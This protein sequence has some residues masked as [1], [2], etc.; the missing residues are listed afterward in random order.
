MLGLNMWLR[1]LFRQ[2]KQ[3]RSGNVAI[4]FGLTCI[5]LL[6]AIGVAV[7]YTRVTDIRAKLDGVAD[8]ATLQ[9]VSKNAN[10]FVTTPTQ[11]QVQQY[12]NTLA[13]NVQGATINTT[14]ATITPSVTNLS[15]TLNYTAQIPTVFGGI[16][17]T[18]S[19][20]VSGTSTAQVNAPPYVNFYLLL[21]NS[22]S[23]GLGATPAD[24]SN[25]ISL[26]ASQSR[27]FHPM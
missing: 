2:F 21:D 10:P 12:F 14:Q 17:G 9:A 27:P 5:P 8:A 13:A 4:M 26:T 7:D 22:P 1:Q 19:V 11:A 25:L 23:M 24:I 20:A 18:N 15:V 3:S 16:I 6:I